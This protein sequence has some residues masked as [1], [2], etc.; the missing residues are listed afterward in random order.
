MSG[1]KKTESQLKYEN[2]SYLIT[3]NSGR[4]S[5]TYDLPGECSPKY[6]FLQ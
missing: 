6:C 1:T 2:Y 4:K 3:T 5:M